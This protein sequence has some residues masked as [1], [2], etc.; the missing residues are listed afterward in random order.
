MGKR[1]KTPETTYVVFVG[2]K[3][4]F[5]SDWSAC[6][7]QV[8]RYS[9]AVHARY[10]SREEAE[11]AWTRFWD[12][13]EYPELQRHPYND[14]AT[15]VRGARGNTS[16]VHHIA[17]GGIDQFDFSE[18]SNEEGSVSGLVDAQVL[19]PGKCS[20]VLR[21]YVNEEPCSVADGCHSSEGCINAVVYCLALILLVVVYFY[22]KA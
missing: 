22:S 12:S 7:Q 21:S 10:P 2:R 17:P 14:R 9:G 19:E 8:Y 15:H 3:P 5:Y 11:V 6:Q 20:A 16:G 13:R 1:S 4:G 18:A